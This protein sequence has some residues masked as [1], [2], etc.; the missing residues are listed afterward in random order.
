MRSVKD[1]ALQQGHEYQFVDDRLFDYVPAQIMQTP[2][3]TVLPLTDL[4]R[5]GLL[6]DLLNSGYDRA[7][8]VDADVLVFRPEY[9]R[10]PDLCGGM[11]CREVWTYEDENKQIRHR[12]GINN[13]VAAFDRGHPLLDFLHHAALELFAHL[14]PE[15]IH[16]SRIGTDFYT[17]LGRIYPM[18]LLTQVACFSP[19][20]T[21]AL[22]SGEQTYLLRE[23]GDQFGDPFHAVNLSRFKLV[24]DAAKEA[25]QVR[26]VMSEE[27]L[28]RLKFTTMK[29]F[30][31]HS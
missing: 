27:Q 10:I 15:Q 20:I 16:S 31:T 26:D 22:L 17:L 4:A 14:R 11:L 18:R 5:L 1:W 29:N 19:I 13:A 28:L 23:Y 7:I 30:G 2:P 25:P 12:P 24:E 3:S 8:W 6:K 21:R 9:F